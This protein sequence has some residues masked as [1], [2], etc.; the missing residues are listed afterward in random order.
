[1]HTSTHR[2]D[3]GDRFAI[4]Q[5]ADLEQISRVI[6]PKVERHCFI[7][8]IRSSRNCVAQRRAG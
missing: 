4:I 7:L 2:V 5:Y 1:M 8:G 6:W 3:D